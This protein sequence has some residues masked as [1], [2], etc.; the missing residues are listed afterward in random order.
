MT[1]NGKT[2]EQVVAEFRNAEILDAARKAFA[3]K[4]YHGTSVEDIARRA[5]LA[6]GTL[7]LYYDSKRSLYWAAL[8]DG[9]AALCREL[10]R[11]VSSADTTEAKIRAFMST[12]L[13]YFHEHQD[14]FR[15]YYAE[16]GNSVA[17][18][19]SDD[20]K[21]L[22]LLQLQ[23]GEKVIEEAV[24][25]KKLRPLRPDSAASAIMSLTRGVITDRLLG[26]SHTKI[27]EEIEFVFN[28]TWKGLAG[29]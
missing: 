8:K 23:I 17:F 3:E 4:G 1:F 6:K 5:G 14:F 16:F 21:Q 26:L 18:N 27:D 29:R 22:F 9:L 2:K 25:K 24:R 15:V 20:M 10:E 12:K 19:L 13:A 28:L 11:A 7:Y